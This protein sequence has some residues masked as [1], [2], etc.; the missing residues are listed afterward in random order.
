MQGGLKERGFIM[1]QNPLPEQQKAVYDFIKRYH[2]EQD[3]APSIRDVA[4]SL[5]IS[6]A[7]VRTYIEILKAKGYVANTEGVRRSLRIIKTE[8]AQEAEQ[9]R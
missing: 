4:D 1:E 7:A 5:G 6:V 2:A 9:C 8:A 3:I